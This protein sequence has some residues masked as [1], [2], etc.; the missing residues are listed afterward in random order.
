M[1]M[2]YYQEREFWNQVT[3]AVKFQENGLFGLKSPTGEIILEAQYDKVEVCADFVY[4]HY[5]I[6]HKYYYKN[7]GMS[8]CEDRDDYRFYENG[9]IGLHYSDGS[10]F[11][12]AEYDEI[13]DWG[14]GSDVVYVRKGKEYHYYNHNKEEIL[15]DVQD[16][17]EDAY[18]ECPYNLGEDQN[19]NVLL[20]VEPIPIHEGNRDCFAY[21]QWVRL[22][23]IP[24]KNV[25]K[26][27]SD[28]EIVDISMEAIENFED[29]CT[30]IY[31]ARKCLSKNENPITT[32][33]E[34]F[35]TLG[36]YVST[37]N[38]L[39]K[40]NVN[41]NTVINPHDLYNANIS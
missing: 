40:I 11:L 5:G 10:V 15:T 39:L 36:C 28:C 20:C 7:G 24:Y 31:S 6:R 12:P 35:K 14:S 25:R 19:R 33:I 32:S 41:R 3:S 34:K 29:E 9:K 23:R 37:W 18:P 26:I 4:A 27:F 13:I 8:D 2:N 16:I 22:S 21:G 38:Y 1:D 17:E 30:Y